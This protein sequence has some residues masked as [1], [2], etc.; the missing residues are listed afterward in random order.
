MPL[1]PTVT[2]RQF[3]RT[4]AISA[5]T[6]AMTAKSYSRIIGANER[7]NF[8]LLGFGLIGRRVQAT[9]GRVPGART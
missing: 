2:R 5:A 8:G 4:A 7:V 1:T 9:H 3:L 6:T